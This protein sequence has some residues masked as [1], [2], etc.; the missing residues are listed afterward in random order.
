MPIEFPVKVPYT[1]APNMVRN[2]GSILNFSPNLDYIR[3]KNLELT[4][5]GSELWAELPGASLLVK[6]ATKQLGLVETSSI[7]NFALQIEEDVAV[8]FHGRLIAI[9][10]CFPS[11]WIPRERIGMTLADIHAPV[12]DGDRLRQ[13]SQRIAQTMADV[14]QTGFRR[15]VWTITNSGDLSQHPQNKCNEIPQTIEDL[16]FRLETQT[17]MPLGD[18]ESSLFFVRVE[19]EPLSVFW[20]DIEKRNTLLASI[21][22]MTDAVLT[23]KNLHHIKHLLNTVGE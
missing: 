11:S 19:T 18:G 5:Y 10:F 17:T 7:V 2:T 15:H 3:Q 16:W 23:Y 20:S 22:S 1:T 21:N 13:M 9:C 4:K 14:K 12:A 6:Q 8:L